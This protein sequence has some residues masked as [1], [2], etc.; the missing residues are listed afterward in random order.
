MDDRREALNEIDRTI[1]EALDVDVSPDFMARVRQRVATESMREPFWRGWRIVLPAAA[2]AV[3]LVAVGASMVSTRPSATPPSLSVQSLPPE[4]ARP[5]GVRPA[6]PVSASDTRPAVAR[7]RVPSSAPSAAAP[8]E[9]EV[10][11]PREEIDMYRRLIAQAQNVPG[12][13]LVAAPPDIVAVRSISDIPIDPIKI[14]LIIPS[15][16]GEGDRQ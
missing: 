6:P 3:V 10:L 1:A 11:V 7:A 5:V 16:D 15:V 2:A 12:A 14:D 13:L 4:S 9:P 8:R